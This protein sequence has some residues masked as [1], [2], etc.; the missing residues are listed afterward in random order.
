MNV[1]RT[2]GFAIAG[3]ALLG[4]AAL[5]A[6]A[7]MRAAHVISNIRLTRRGRKNMA[8]LQKGEHGRV[9]PA[10]RDVMQNPPRRWDKVDE[11]SDASFPASDPPANY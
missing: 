2:N 11:E 8:S 10:G 6:A 1:Q 5:T 3:I 9:R 4:I 7:G